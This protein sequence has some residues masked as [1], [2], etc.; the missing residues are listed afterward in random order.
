MRTLGR[1]ACILLVFALLLPAPASAAKTKR[2]S[3]LEEVAALVAEK[4]EGLEKTYTIPCEWT[5]VEKLKSISSVGQNT[6][7]LSEILLQSGYVST[8]AVGWYDH[9]V[10]LADISYY[11]GCPNG[12]GRRWTR[13][14]R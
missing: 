12:R 1:C 9:E 3:T 2:L 5:L 4:A 11:P 10:Y 13:R 7:L 6:T 14:W 8:F